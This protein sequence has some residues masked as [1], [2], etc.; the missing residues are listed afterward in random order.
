M[1]ERNTIKHNEFV[2]CGD[3]IAMPDVTDCADFRVFVRR[4]LKCELEFRIQIG[5]TK[6]K[7]RGYLQNP[8]N[9]KTFAG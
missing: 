3:F 4:E 6:L 1:S 9:Q 8:Q 2:Y 7:N 5:K